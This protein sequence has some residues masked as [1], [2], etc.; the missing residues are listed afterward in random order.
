MNSALRAM[1][2]RVENAPLPSSYRALGAMPELK[3]HAG[4]GALLDSLADVEREREAFGAIG[5]V[6][7]VFVALTARAAA[8]GR[9]IQEAAKT[10]VAEAEAELERLRPPAPAPVVIVPTV[11]TLPMV[12][13]RDAAVARLDSTARR[14]AQIRADN[15]EIEQRAERARTTANIASPPMAMLA[16]ALVLA[17]VL[18]FAVSLT[19]EMRAPRIADPEEAE[20]TTGIRVLAVVTPRERQPERSRRRIDR[21]TSPLLDAT[22]D[23]YR[24]LYLHIAG[25]VPRISLITVTGNDPVL[26]AVVGSNIGTA[27]AYDARSTL[28]I[29]A[30]LSACAVSSLLRVRSEPGLG[31]VLAGRVDW[32]EAIASATIGRERTLDVIPGGRCGEPSSGFDAEP[33]RHDLARIARRYDLVVLVVPVPHIT[34]G[35]E[36]ILPT[37]DVILCGHLGRTRVD[38][39]RESVQGLRGAGARIRGLVLWD[40]DAPV[41]NTG[42]HVT[43]TRIDEALPLSSGGS[44]R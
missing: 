24:L 8:I 22:S 10:T 30:D 9:S 16:A 40:G 35:A 26:S 42:P 3:D 43:E 37:P 27:S 44:A 29:D 25:S 4:V 28:L 11:D 13:R 31:E 34:R 23:A 41:V 32:T 5:G 39:L 2:A 36:S 38:E 21:E 19:I 7:P 33:T 18:G 14:L 15:A 17:C 20:E 6:D 12:H 1:L